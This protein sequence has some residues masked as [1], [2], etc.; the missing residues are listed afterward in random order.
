MMTALK[1]SSAI[2]PVLRDALDVLSEGIAVFDGDGRAVLWNARYAR[3]WASW[4]VTLSPGVLFSDLLRAGVAAGRYDDVGGDLDVWVAEM[5]DRRMN[6][7][8]FDDLRFE[9]G[10][11]LRFHTRPTPT[12]GF[13][14]TCL[15]VT[16]LKEREKKALAAQSFLDTVV[17]NVP[18]IMVVKDGETGRFLLANR[19][20]EEAMGVSRNDLLGKSDRD[21]FPQDQADYFMDWDRRVLA[22]GEVWTIEEEPLDTPH[23]GRRWLQTRKVGVPF[24]DGRRHLLTICQDI[25]ERKQSA[26]ALAE[27][28]ERAEAAS[29]AKSEFLANMS[30]EIRTPLNGVIGLAEVM[31]R[32]ELSDDQR[33]M[34]QTIIAS[35]RTLNRLLCD[36]LDLSKVE[37]GQLAL[38]PEP[39]DLRDA[40]S[41]AV[42]VFEAVAREKGVG[43]EVSFA[44]DFCPHV[45][46]DGLR[47]RQIVANLTSNAVKFTSRGAVCIHAATTP[48]QDGRVALSVSVADTGEGFDAEAGDRLFERFQQADGSVTRKFGGS[49]LGLPIARQFARLMGGD[50]GWTAKKGAGATFTFRA[51]LPLSEICPPVQAAPAQAEALDRPLRILL[52]EDHPVNQKVVLMMLAD[53]AEVTVAADGRAALEAFDAARFDV[54]L[55]DSQMPVMDGLAATRAIR[56]REAARGLAATPIVSLT[57]NAMPHQIEASLAAGANLHLAK[58]VSMDALFQTLNAALSLGGDGEVEARLTA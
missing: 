10:E 29:V 18:A 30:H 4:G 46:A 1:S 21:L 42:S 16:D 2:D 45:L 48:A 32:T 47:I 28:L 19:F 7:E 57:A 3:T 49:G 36:I 44:D 52:A 11:Y 27:A 41:S 25:T 12:G 6:G 43:F 8:A 40:I 54:I 53:A 58:P 56:E 9:F 24:A 38:A 55:M 20:A 31:S 34:I 15:D 23:N 50:I 33:E 51:L 17:E 14:V 13:V 35:G 39:L 26:A 22:S 37:S 5:V